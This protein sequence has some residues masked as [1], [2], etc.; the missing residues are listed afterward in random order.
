MKSKLFLG[1]TFLL[2]GSVVSAQ[3]IKFGLRA[4]ANLTKVDG[5]S[6]Q[7][8]FKFGYHLGGAAEIMFNKKWGIQ[9]EVIFNQSNTQTGYGFDTLYESIN[10]G[11]IKDVKLN[12]LSM[13][14]LLTYRP[15]G[16]ISFQAGPQFGILMSQSKS[17]L[18]DGEEAFKNGDLSLVGGVQLQLINFRVYGRYGIGLNNINDID[19]QDKWKNQTVQIGVGFMF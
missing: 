17:L 8:E 18:E 12:Y 10:P 15:S 3:G 11:T 4:G 1:L 13:P 2:I 5:Q 16:I 14:I 9:P 19:N 6:F 7:D